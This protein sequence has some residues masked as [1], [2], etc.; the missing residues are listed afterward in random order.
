MAGKA[1]VLDP[2][3]NVAT[4]VT[5]L[6]KGHQMN[7]AGYSVVLQEPI[8]FGHKLA[9]KA[10]PRGGNVVKY[11]EIMGVASRD[12]EPGEHVHIHNVES[13]RGRGDLARPQGDGGCS[14]CN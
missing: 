1:L 2:R 4:A 14:G 10:I 13:T 11:G 7:V 8:P 3:D 6:P 9:L 12:I 5:D